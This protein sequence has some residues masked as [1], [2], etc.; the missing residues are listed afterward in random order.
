MQFQIILSGKN[1]KYNKLSAVE[2]AI[3][4]FI[5]L[6]LVGVGEFLICMQFSLSAKKKKK[7]ERK[8]IRLI[9]RCILCHLL[10]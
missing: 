2:L 1:K 7:K 5:Q 3:G 9:R 8:K 4:K 10:N 6:Y